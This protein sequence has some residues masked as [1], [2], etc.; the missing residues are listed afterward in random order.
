MSW[1]SYIFPQTILI[2]SSSFNRLIRVNEEWGKMKLLVNMSPQSGAY[3]EKL[4]KETFKHFHLIPG[5]KDAPP[6]AGGPKIRDILVL[7]LGGGTVLTML[8]R[9]FPEALQTCVDIDPI[10]IDIAKKYFSVGNIPHLSLVHA[11]AE[12]YVNHT[13]RERKKYDCVIVDLSFGRNIPAFVEEQHFLKEIKT[14]LSPS[15]YLLLNYLREKEYRNKSNTLFRTLQS[16][17]PTVKDF[18]IAN[19]RF[20]FCK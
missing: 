5:I 6:P 11:D 8:S 15:G 4:W 16:V 1:K 7:G 20:F 17:F 13:V 18:E 9:L 10:V 19:N 2:T 3:I 12:K 14:L